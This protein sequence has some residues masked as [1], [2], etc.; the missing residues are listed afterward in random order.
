VHCDFDASLLPL[1]CAC[2]SPGIWR[3]KNLSINLLVRFWDPEQGRILMGGQDIRSFSETDLRRCISV[4]SQQAH[5]FAATLRKNLLLARPQATETELVAALER[6]QLLDFVK[7]LPEGLDT[8]IG[9]FG[10]Q[11]S[12]GQARRLA[13]ARAVLHDAPVWVLDEPTEGLDRITEQQLIT[14]LDELTVDR[15]LL[16]IT[17]RMV[18]LE[19]MDDIVL[20]EEGRVVG[21]GSHENLLNS[22]PRYAALQ[23]GEPWQ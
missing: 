13:L 7:D 5:L 8:W 22:S 10:K 3:R 21:R 1:P 18:N 12:A 2:K 14:A 23:M 11:L 20:L 4:V 17:H 16:L 9:E 19:R 6:V 15:T